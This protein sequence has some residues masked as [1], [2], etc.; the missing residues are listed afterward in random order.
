MR[1]E[2][3]RIHRRQRKKQRITRPKRN[4][5]R[6]RRWVQLDPDS[7]AMRAEKEE[8]LETEQT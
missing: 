6:W 5:T 1:V 8:R 3:G 2:L 7:Q 4:K